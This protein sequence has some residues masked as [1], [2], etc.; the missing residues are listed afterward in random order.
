MS[1][2]LGL[3][4]SRAVVAG[5]RSGDRDSG[6]VDDE[7]VQ[8][9]HLTSQQ[10]RQGL[11]AR[12]GEPEGAICHLAVQAVARAAPVQHD[13]EVAAIIVDGLTLGLEVRPLVAELLLVGG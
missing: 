3:R 5:L 7:V 6:L 11:T 9:V 10:S 8:R 4:W 2:L 1:G 13:M 12:S